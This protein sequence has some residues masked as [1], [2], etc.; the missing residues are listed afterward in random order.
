[1]LTKYCSEYDD[2]T[3][4]IFNRRLLKCFNWFWAV[5]KYEND[6]WAFL[7]NKKDGFLEGWGVSTKSNSV[8][9]VQKKSFSVSKKVFPNFLSRF[10]SGAKPSGGIRPSGF[11]A[12]KC[13]LCGRQ[14]RL[15]SLLILLPIL[16]SALMLKNNFI[17]LEISKKTVCKISANFLYQ[18]PKW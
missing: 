7:K 15:T 9:V 18:L 2:A 6:F 1:M 13:F 16:T 14:K 11:D 8:Q 4:V 5:L 17:E 3:V 10:V 12:I